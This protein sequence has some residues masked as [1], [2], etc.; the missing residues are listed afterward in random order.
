MLLIAY[1]LFESSAKF[2]ANLLALALV[3][4]NLSLPV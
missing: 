3:I 2:E 1:R 4:R